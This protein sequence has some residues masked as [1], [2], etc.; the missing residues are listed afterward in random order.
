MMNR[1]VMVMVAAIA[2]LSVFSGIGPVSMKVW[3]IEMIWA[4]GLVAILAL[5]WTKF[6]FS[7]MSYS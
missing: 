3:F 6:R 5:T 2:V 4:W 7:M 1:M